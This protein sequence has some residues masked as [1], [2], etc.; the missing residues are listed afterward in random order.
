M[1]REPILVVMAAGM[2]S[3][4][5]GMKQIDPLGKNGEIIIDYSLFDAIRAGFK[6]V[7]F[8]IQKK[9][10]EDF[11]EV[12]GNRISKMMEVQYAFQDI[13][14]LPD[15]F[16]LPEGRTKPWGTGHAVRACRHL[17]DAP[18]AVINADDF[19]GREGF[20]QIY[21]FLS[22]VEDGEPYHFAMVGYVLKN[23]LTDNGYVSRGVCELNGENLKGITERTRIERSEDQQGA[24]FSEDGGE[25]WT[26]L[27]PESVVSMNLWGFTPS[28]LKEMESGFTA[29]LQ[30]ALDTNPLKAEYYLP[31]VVNTLLDEGRAQVKV[32]RS[33]DKWYGV[34]YREDKPVVQAALRKMMEDGVYPDP[35]FEE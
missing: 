17:I 2:G 31:S 21:Q 12:V 1:N 23:T 11:C 24:C 33:H 29:F 18:F 14:D 15:G 28:V 8:I 32:L 13:E 16:S 25:T 9:N 26:A 3:R 34:T 30:D 19:Y 22:R 6:R 5:G 27:D 7:I 20:A 4:Y 10:Y 35:L